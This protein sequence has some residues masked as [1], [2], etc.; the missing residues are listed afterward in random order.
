MN[1][2]NFT[3]EEVWNFTKNGILVEYEIRSEKWK[4]YTFDFDYSWK[5]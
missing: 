2:I 3:F 5:V 1:W 4:R